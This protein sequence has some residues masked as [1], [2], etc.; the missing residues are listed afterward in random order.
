MSLTRFG[1]WRISRMTISD[2]YG[3]IILFN[4]HDP[5]VGVEVRL[6]SGVVVKGDAYSF[7]G[8]IETNRS[9]IPRDGNIYVVIHTGEKE[10]GV[11][12][13]YGRE[14]FIRGKVLL[15]EEMTKEGKKAEVLGVGLPIQRGMKV[16]FLRVVG[17]PPKEVGEEEDT[18][19]ALYS[20]MNMLKSRNSELMKRNEILSNELDQL[21][22]VYKEVVGKYETCRE[23]MDR[24]YFQLSSRIREAEELIESARTLQELREAAIK[25]IENLTGEKS[26]F[27]A[28]R[29]RK[30]EEELEKR[31]KELKKE[32]EKI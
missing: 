16:V 14:V 21:R 19:S 23:A 1:I 27:A 8:G 15:V 7:F 24:L 29:K 5:E 3:F 26:V 32:A 17:F 4:A 22:K 28:V 25:M 10:E 31:I 12:G 20:D 6:P 2:P 13:I 11:R 9:D 18:L 30:E